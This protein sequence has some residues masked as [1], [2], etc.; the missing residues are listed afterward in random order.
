MGLFGDIVGGALGALGF[1]HSSSM[2]KKNYQL[3]KQYMEDQNAND[4][5][6]FELAQAQHA[7]QMKAQQTTWNREDNAMQRK[8]SDLEKAGL[9]PVLAAGGPGAPTSSPAQID[10]PQKA[11]GVPPPVRPSRGME[12]AALA[13]SLMT[14]RSQ[15][16]KT[17]A[18]KRLI[19][20]QITESTQRTLGQSLNNKLL[21]QEASKRQLEIDL[22]TRDFNILKGRPGQLYREGGGVMALIDQITAALAEGSIGNQTSQAMSAIANKVKEVPGLGRMLETH[23]Q[24]LDALKSSKNWSQD[25][26]VQQ[27]YEEM[28]IFRKPVPANKRGL[29]GR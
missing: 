5:R 11:R 23:K 3:Q 29:G 20:A 24:S 2:D 22:L 16:G 9:N 21:A 17:E 26:K 6:N 18:E 10:A 27:F 4:M 1:G 8:V 14:Q 15:V 12:A 13:S 19:D 25:R 7:W 28:G